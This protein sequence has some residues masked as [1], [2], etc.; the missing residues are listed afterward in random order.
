ME[1][2]ATRPPLCSHVAALTDKVAAY[3]TRSEETRAALEWVV[4]QLQ[5]L[6]LPQPRLCSFCA[7]MARERLVLN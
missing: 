7:R 2:A 1:Q 3:P 4:Q 5:D 6:A